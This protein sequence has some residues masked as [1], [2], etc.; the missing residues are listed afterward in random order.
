MLV[1]DEKS[2]LLSYSAIL[3]FCIL[4]EAINGKTDLRVTIIIDAIDNKTSR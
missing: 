1:F 4:L 3:I 2:E